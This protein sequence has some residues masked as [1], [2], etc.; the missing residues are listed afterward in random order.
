M[1]IVRNDSIVFVFTFLIVCNLYCSMFGCKGS[2]PAQNYFNQPTNDPGFEP[3]VPNCKF[4]TIDLDGFSFSV[5]RSPHG[6]PIVVYIS[7]VSQVNTNG[8]PIVSMIEVN[9]SD[10]TGWHD[11][12]TETLEYYRDEREWSEMPTYTLTEPGE[13]FIHVR[14]TFPDGDLID[15][16]DVFPKTTQ[17]ITVLPPDEGDD[18]A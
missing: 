10:G 2:G 16:E 7:G 1:K 11:Y 17:T 3:T 6:F 9:F 15:N 13:Y 18:G 4:E 5:G 12:T 14:V 8:A